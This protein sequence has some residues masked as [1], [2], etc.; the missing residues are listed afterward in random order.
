MTRNRVQKLDD[1][2]T[3]SQDPLGLLLM[4]IAHSHI[5]APV[6]PVTTKLFITRKRKG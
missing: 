1:T 3:M 4:L 6:A 2:E 5:M